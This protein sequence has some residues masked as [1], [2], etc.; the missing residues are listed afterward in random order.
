ML[1]RALR[2]KGPGA[3]LLII[4]AF[5]AV[6][7][8]AWLHPQPVPDSVY[9]SNPMPMY[10]LLLKLCSGNHT[11]GMLITFAVLAVITVLIELFSDNTDFLSERS[12]ILPFIY[13][14]SGGIF[15]I[16]QQLNPVLP[17]SLFL[18]LALMSIMKGYHK[19]DIV[20][21]FFDAGFL[22]SFGSL[23]Y[24][25]LI[26]FGILVIIGI[27]LL[28]TGK[29]SEII[30]A[31]LG[32]AGPWFLTYGILYVT[33]ADI[34]KLADIIVLNLFHRGENAKYAIAQLV[35][36]SVIAIGLLASMTNMMTVMNKKKIK[37]RKVFSLL[38]STF[39]ITIT[40][41]LA[42]PSASSEI[43]WILALPSAYFLS[44]YL[45]TSRRRIFPEIYLVLIIG[46]VA[47][48]Q[49]SLLG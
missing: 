26:W 10:G 45:T 46:L 43:F 19:P 13:I 5:A 42:V 2:G 41:F 14:V 22:I 33:G 48:I 17:A 36:L 4:I 49:L 20:H 7:S 25:N 3:F 39:L 15:P 40:V 44:F 12:L 31:V 29:P 47:F 18:L 34:K 16:H 6:W 21:N 11:I 24:A 23:F 28:R 38:I 35:A 37:S 9:Q 1:L 27:G 8:S 32:L 30:I